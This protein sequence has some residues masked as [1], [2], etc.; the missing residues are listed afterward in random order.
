MA[1]CGGA[2]DLRIGREDLA[3]LVFGK[4]DARVRHLPPQKH[5]ATLCLAATSTHD[6][7]ADVGELH[8]VA[9]EVQQHLTQA[10]G[11][12]DRD[13]R[14]VRL[15]VDDEL[16]ALVRG[17]L[18]EQ[19]DRL[20]GHMLGAEVDRLHAH[21]PGLDLR[22]VENVVDDLEQRVARRANRLDVIALLRR[23]IRAQQ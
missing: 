19:L 9:D 18:G 6:H 20:F 13:F 16:D 4:A 15:D 22:E 23:D 8:S 11:V 12:A 3:S 10:T 17:S 2:V 14:D 21:A 7:L 1:T 5:P